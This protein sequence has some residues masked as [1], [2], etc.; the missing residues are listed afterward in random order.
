MSFDH[1]FQR[2]GFCER[3]IDA[4]PAPD[5]GIVVVVPCFNEPDLIGSLEALWSC[6]RP[7]GAVEVIVV[8]NSS[9]NCPPEI[10][11]QNRKTWAEAAAWTKEHSQARLDFHL[12]QFPNL[13]RKQ[14]GVGLARKI[15]M[16]EAAH[17]FGQV[18]RPEGVIVC[19]DV[20][21]RCDANY[22][23]VVEKHFDRHRDSPGCS[24][25]FEHPLEGP[26]E[27]QIY[28]AAAAYELHLRYYLQALRYA[29]FPHAYHTIGSCMAVRAGAYVKQ[30][31]MNKR[32]AGE[33]FYFLQK[34]ISL[35]GFTE[36]NS[37]RVLPSPRR[38]NRVPFGTGKAVGD[39]LKRGVLETYPQQAFLDLKAL[40]ECLPTFYSAGGTQTD[41]VVHSFSK[42]LRTFLEAQGF[43][44]VI[45]EIR[46][47]T[48]TE[49]AFRK[50]FFHWFNGFRVMKF[51]RHASDPFYGKRSVLEE[52]AR[53]LEL[54]PQAGGSFIGRS[55]RDVLGA[56]RMLERAPTECFNL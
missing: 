33:D 44:G 54:L 7:R 13:P 27:P 2:C 50:R 34:I 29:G 55:M 4:P 20:D 51:V 12:L 18:N 52:A 31:G 37:T 6:D 16:D 32:Q 15:G 26:M 21:C 53:L 11:A 40:F 56:Y 43:D 24:I 45:R 41:K 39:Y 36:L 38:S 49:A 35:G 30:G 22:L 9:A 46:Q 47:N 42:P 1:Y 17:R 5:L 3:Q 25:Y 8:I 48:A 23:A 19:F 14:A 28:D 10:L